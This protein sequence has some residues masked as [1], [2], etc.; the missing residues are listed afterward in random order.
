MFYQTIKIKIGTLQKLRLL[1][2]YTNQTMLG[3]I[4]NFVTKELEELNEKT[5]LIKSNEKWIGY[6][7]SD[8]LNDL[9]KMRDKA[10]GQT[11][12]F[13]RQNE[14][15]ER[16]YADAELGGTNTA[17]DSQSILASF[18]K[19]RAIARKLQERWIK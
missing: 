17:V 3:L 1:S 12:N 11:D 13:H 4:E 7:D 2:A 14:L 16:R 9:K 19:H 6:D 10:I 5:H 8:P 15:E 18:V